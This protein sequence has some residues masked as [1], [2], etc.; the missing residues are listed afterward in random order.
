MLYFP[1]VETGPDV[2]EQVDGLQSAGP[3]VHEN[4]QATILLAEDSEMIRTMTTELLETAGYRVLVAELPSVALAIARERDDIDLL[5]SDVV[6]PEMDGQ[7]LHQQLQLLKPE[8]PAIF[9]SG[10]TNNIILHDGAPKEGYN[11]LYKPFTSQQLLDAVR[12]VIQNQ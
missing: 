6:M 10:Y 12:S 1:A 2:P 3:V 7:E 8:L 5:I 4:G 11:F 9:I